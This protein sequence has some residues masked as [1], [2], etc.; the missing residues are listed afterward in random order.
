[1]IIELRDRGVGIPEDKQELVFD[2][3]SRLK[4]E[5]SRVAGTGLGLAISRTIMESQGGTIHVT[6]HAEG[7]AV[8]TLFFPNVRIIDSTCDVRA[9]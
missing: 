8:F 4:L 5:D 7:G 6:N 3:Y 2:K 1:M 9:S